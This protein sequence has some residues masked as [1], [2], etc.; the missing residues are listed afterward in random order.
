MYVAFVD[1]FVHKVIIWD[2]AIKRSSA[3]HAISDMTHGSLNVQ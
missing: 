3:V 2:L 1:C